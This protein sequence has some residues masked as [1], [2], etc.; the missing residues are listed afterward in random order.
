M[1]FCLYLQVRGVINKLASL[2]CFINYQQLFM[3]CYRSL[4]RINLWGYAPDLG[5]TGILRIGVIG[6][7][8][9]CK[10]NNCL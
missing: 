2:L 9:R 3:L 4:V 8:H 5:L 10:R 6:I 7:K 1:G